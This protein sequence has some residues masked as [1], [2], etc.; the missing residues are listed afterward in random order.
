MR[1]RTKVK[2]KKSN[3]IAATLGWVVEED[4]VQKLSRRADGIL[5][6]GRVLNSI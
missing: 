2:R 4:P 5:L 1:E 6:L 3:N